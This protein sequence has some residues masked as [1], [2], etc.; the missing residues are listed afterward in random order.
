MRGKKKKDNLIWFKAYGL[1]LIIFSLF[2]IGFNILAQVETAINLKDYLNIKACPSFV[3]ENDLT[4]KDQ[5][6]GIIWARHELPTY[7]DTAAH[8]EASGTE[9]GYTWQEASNACAALEPAGMFRL[10]TVEELMRLIRYKCDDNNCFVASDIA[11]LNNQGPIFAS[12]TY[13]SSNDFN[14]PVDWI[15]P[16][17]STP[18]NAGR[19]Y[20]RSVNLLSGLA[21][22]PVLGKNV[23][24]NVWCIVE[25]N[26]EVIDKEFTST[27]TAAISHGLAASSGI[28]K[29]IFQRSCNTAG[30]DDCP[31][32]IYNTT[33]QATSGGTPVSIQTPTRAPSCGDGSCNGDETCSSCASDCGAC[34]V[35]PPNVSASCDLPT[36]SAT[37]TSDNCFQAYLNGTEIGKSD[38]FPSNTITVTDINGASLNTGPESCDPAWYKTYTYNNLSYISGRNVIAFKVTDYGGPYGLAAQFMC[39]TNDYIGFLTTNNTANWKCSAPLARILNGTNDPKDSTGKNWYDPAFDDTA[40]TT[41][42]SVSSSLWNN[43]THIGNSDVIIPQS[44]PLSSINRIWSNYGTGTGV[45]PSPYFFP[46]AFNNSTKKI[47]CR[48]YFQGPASCTGQT[49]DNAT[50]CPGADSGLTANVAKTAVGNAVSCSGTKCEYACNPGSIL[51]GGNCVVPAN[52]IVSGIIYDAR[53][54]NTISGA[55]IS[56]PGQPAVT[57]NTN[58]SY[59]LTI[60]QGTYRFDVSKAGYHAVYI[61]DLNVNKNISQDFD[62]LPSSFTSSLTTVAHWG[63]AGKDKIKGRWKA[64]QPSGHD[65]NTDKMDTYTI[66]NMQAYTTTYYLENTQPN[67]TP[68]NTDV[69]VRVWASDGRLIKQYIS[70]D[71]SSL[72]RQYWVIFNLEGASVTDVNGSTGN[73]TNTHP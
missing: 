57:S 7:Y 60:N 24:L 32:N 39:G 66:N 21:D 28:L 12:G 58:G 45:G 61:A 9:P 71:D 17:A 69:Q 59:T 63:T 5:C 47:F 70:L 2:F 51:T 44:V 22:S 62:L 33:C 16:V 14:E 15:N 23:K 13:W 38:L 65:Y 37:I 31:Q 35:T 73:Y 20:K 10:P 41:P 68:F 19:D 6:T 67:S 56:T 54:G 8:L 29:T 3:N 46:L 27:T 26:P 43:F 25:R 55:S 72:K 36:G 48:V 49:P 40:W 34:E 30:V 4:I 52:F 18:G 42:S 53:T 1:I 11:Y 50:L 64:P